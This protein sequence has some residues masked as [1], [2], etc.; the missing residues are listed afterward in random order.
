MFSGWERLL[1]LKVEIG[2]HVTFLTT[3]LH[4]KY[5]EIP[6][7]PPEMLERS[8]LSFTDKQFGEQFG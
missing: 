7:S 1:I 8:H 5:S 3:S 4:I 2:L 6:L